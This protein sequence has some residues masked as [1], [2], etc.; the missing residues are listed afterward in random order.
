MAKEIHIVQIGV[1]GVGSALVRQ[2]L[3]Q[4]DQLEQRY[5]FILGYLALV[6]REAAIA[7]GQM[8]DR[9]TLKT[10]VTARENQQDLSTLPAAL[11]S[12][13]WQQ[14]LPDH[15][16]IIVDATAADGMETGLVAAVQAG[17]RVVLANKRPLCGPLEIYRSLTA[18]GATRYEVTVGAGLPIIDTL[19]RLM[20]SGD[21]LISIEASLSGT[22]GYLCTEL[23]QGNLF[24]YA[25]GVAHRCG[26]TEPDPRDDLSGSDVARKALILARLCGLPWTMD[27]V[28]VT[29]WLSPA[30][31]GMDR[32]PS[33][34]TVDVP[35]FMERVTEMD[36]WYSER[37]NRAHHHRKSFRYHARITPEGASIGFEELDPD[38]PIARLRGTDNIVI[39]TTA[40]YSGSTPPL[41]VQGPGAGREVTAAGVLGDIVATARELVWITR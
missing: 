21:R 18:H 16:C 30:Y 8:L 36:A 32:L 37:V 22:L 3:E 4:Q 20:D 29:P 12:T 39:I 28:A 10:I 1:G 11:P 35:T 33:L 25:I 13:S 27:H 2:V 24:S 19:Q 41:V 15:P 34:L 17:H 26:W 14:F 9:E 7:T 38:H 6:E 23:E 40:R 5:G 31:P